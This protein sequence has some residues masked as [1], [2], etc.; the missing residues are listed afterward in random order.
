M[1]RMARDRL[2]MRTLAIALAAAAF[3]VAMS[4]LKGNDI[5]IRDDVGNLSA[6]WLLLPFAAGTAAGRRVL[7]GAVVGLLATVV[8]L[9]A[10][11]VANAFVLDLGPHSIVNDL[12]LTVSPSDY[13]VRLGLVSG[14]VFGALGALWRRRGYPSV[15][16]AVVLLL[17]AE[18]LFWEAA[19]RTHALPRF[20]FQPSLAASVSEAG[21]G[22]LAFSLTALAVRRARSGAALPAAE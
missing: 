12:R 14:P 3:G 21:V 7:V 4:I 11:Y 2:V 17:V 10:F 22:V 5:G 8:A 18:P 15:G 1:V 16:L 19:D 9:L 6:P 13:W 20:A